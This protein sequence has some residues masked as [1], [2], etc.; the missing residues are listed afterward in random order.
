MP[1]VPS[2]DHDHVGEPDL[3]P[4]AEPLVPTGYGGNYEI[5]GNP[6]G[7]RTTKETFPVR[8]DVIVRTN[9]EHETTHEEAVE[10]LKLLDELASYGI[11]VP[12]HGAVRGPELYTVTQRV[13][14][15]D[16]FKALEHPTQ[17]LVEQYEDLNIGL[18]KYFRDKFTGHGGQYLRDFLGMHQYVYGKVKGDKESKIYLV[19]LDFDVHDVEPDGPDTQWR[20]QALLERSQW[21][22]YEIKKAEGISGLRFDRSREALL[23]SLDVY[24]NDEVYNH[25]RAKVREVLE[26]D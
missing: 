19:D 10:G 3:A 7:L 5:M 22:A 15:E 23:D 11:N 14:G 20:S 17:E 21:I 6:V 25:H 13:E 1:E 26:N 4:F 18:V 9:S 24:P 2:P 12:H 8:S 16:L